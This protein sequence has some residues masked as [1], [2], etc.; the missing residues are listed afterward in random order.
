[1]R[2]VHAA[3]DG[4][5]ELL[6]RDYV[7]PHNQ[8]DVYVQ[9]EASLFDNVSR[10]VFRKEHSHGQLMALA[11]VPVPRSDRLTKA[12][13]ITAGPSPTIKNGWQAVDWHTNPLDYTDLAAAAQEAFT[14]MVV[15]QARRATEIA[16]IPR[17][18]CAGGVFLN[19]T[20][21]SAILRL[22]TVDELYIPSTPHDAGISVGAAYLGFRQLVG[23]LNESA[24]TERC[25]SDF[26]G[27]P[28]E[29]VTTEHTIVYGLHTVLPEPDDTALVR[30]VCKVLRDGA[31]VARYAGR[32][33]FGPRALG[34]RSILCHPIRCTDARAKLNSIKERQDWRPVAPILREEDLSDYF[35]GPSESPFMN[36]NFTVRDRYRNQLREAL[37]LYGTARV[38]TVSAE[39]GS[40]IYHLL[41]RLAEI[42]EVPILINTSLNGPAQP[43]LDSG[44]DVLAFV[45]N[46]AIDHL[47]TADQ[48]FRCDGGAERMRVRIKSGAV[49]ATFGSGT[50][51]RFTLSDSTGVYPIGRSSFYELCEDEEVHVVQRRDPLIVAVVEAG[52][53]IEA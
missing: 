2:S 40:D 52:L 32:A 16:K 25:R 21:N 44:R 10:F 38:Q 45:A 49:L 17:L 18:C 7:R 24:D 14:E 22:E 12:G 35:E 3:R 27:F 19:L 8:P 47:M 51:A 36:F 46:T 26:L 30:E 9:S 5:F 53:I 42:G 37:H 6:S 15:F 1:M 48:L 43:I 34:N 50:A 28:A 23:A 11:G 31:I 20:G 33:E 29:A 4:I 13:I 39:Y 41:C